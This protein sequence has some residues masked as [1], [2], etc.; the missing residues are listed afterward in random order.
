[1]VKDSSEELCIPCY[2]VLLELSPKLLVLVERHEKSDLWAMAQED[3][4]QVMPVKMISDNAG[5][6]LAMKL[7]MGLKHDTLTN[8]RTR[9]KLGDQILASLL[10]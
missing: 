10:C 4:F 9:S 8:M 3:G 2:R 7:E 5:Q 6:T 1:M